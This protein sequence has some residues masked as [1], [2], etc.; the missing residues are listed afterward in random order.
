MTYKLMLREVIKTKQKKPIHPS[1]V[2]GHIWG[3]KKNGQ[4]VII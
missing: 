1:C 2:Y 4:V 3:S